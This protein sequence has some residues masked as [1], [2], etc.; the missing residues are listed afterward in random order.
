MRLQKCVYRRNFGSNSRQVNCQTKTK[1]IF[2]AAF[3]FP[4]SSTM[5]F[6]GMSVCEKEILKN[7]KENNG[8]KLLGKYLKNQSN[9]KLQKQKHKLNTKKYAPQVSPLGGRQ[10][11]GQPAGQLERCTFNN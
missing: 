5:A 8:V 7:K 1:A 2:N 10:T 4:S 6:D 9:K 11:A 3:H